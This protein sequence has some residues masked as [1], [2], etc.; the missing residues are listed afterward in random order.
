MLSTFH[1]FTSLPLEI[2][3]MIWELTFIPRVIELLYDQLY[4]QEED[5]D[6]SSSNPEVTEDV[7][8]SIADDDLP[9]IAALSVCQESR[10]FAKKSGYRPWKLQNLSDEIKQV[11]WNPAFDT[12]SCGEMWGYNI[13]LY[14]PSW[15]LYKQFPIEA[16]LVRFM[17][18]PSSQWLDVHDESRCEFDS[19]GYVEFKSLKEIC[20][21]IDIPS[22]YNWAV[23]CMES[24]PGWNFRGPVLLPDSIEEYLVKENSLRSGSNWEVPTLRV[25]ECAKVILSSKT[26]RFVLRC[27]SCRDM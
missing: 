18:L 15:T 2:R 21:V 24:F 10:R 8:F 12:V 4:Y 13:N 6:S 14:T 23:Q 9:L 1:L 7:R 22:E 26:R 5:D 3:Y 17:A 20:I 11:M 16:K 27:R 25:V 19:G